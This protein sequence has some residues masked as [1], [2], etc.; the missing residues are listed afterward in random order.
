MMKP[1]DDKKNFILAMVLMF[2]VIL[3]WQMFWAKPALQDAQ[4]QAE[5]QMSQTAGQ[6]STGAQQQTGIPQA[7]AAGGRPPGR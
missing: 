3:L 7:P 4:Q 1:H 5:Q 2:G 6:Q